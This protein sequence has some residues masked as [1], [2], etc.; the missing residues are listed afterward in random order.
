[1]PQDLTI[2]HEPVLLSG[3]DFFTVTA[4]EGSLICLSVEGEIIGV[5]EGTG[6]PV[7]ISIE[8]QIP[9]TMVDIVITKQ[10]FFRYETQVQVIPPDGPYVVKHS[11]E[12]NDANGNGQMDYGESILLS[13]AVKNV[14]NE[15]ATNVTVTIGT[16][17][18]YI[19]ITDGTEFY[20][21]VPA[22]SV[23][24]IVDGYAFDVAAD[25][26]DG[27][28]VNFSVVA[29][30]GTDTWNSG[31]SIEG[32]APV[33][34]FAEFVVSGDG[35][36]DPGE[37]VD[38]AITIENTGTSEAFNVMGELLINDP[39]VTINT[40]SQNYGN[41]EG[42]ATAEQSFSVTANANTP[43]GHMAN[44]IVEIAADFGI[45]GLGNFNVV[46]GQIP[47]LILDFDDNTNS[48][49]NMVNS[50]ENLG[51]ACEYVTSM[52]A[53]LNLYTSI[54]VCLGIYSDNH[55]L[56]SGE[57]SILA[58]Y[59]N[60]GGQ[61]YMEG[62]DTWYY[63][64]Q[65]AVHSM[66]NINPQADGSSDLGTILGQAGTIT[67]GLNYNYSGQNS[68]ID[69]INAISPAQLIHQNQSPVY[70]CGVAYDAG[71]YRTIGTS[72]EFGGLD[73]GASTVDQLMEQYLIFFGFGQEP[74]IQTITLNTG[75]QFS[76]TRIAVENPDML[77]VLEPILNENLDFV[78]NSNGEVLRKIGP[79]WVN[80]I[81]DWVTTGGYLF[82]M[83]GAEVLNIEGEVISATTPINLFAGY[84]F[85]SYLPDVPLDAIVAFDNILTDNL[86]Y[87]RNSNGEMLRKIGPNWVNGL[88]DLNPGEGYLVKMFADDLL[89]YN[90]TTDG[91]KNTY[92]PKVMNHFTF[93]GGNPAEAV[94][95]LYVSGLNIGD[96]VAVYDGDKMVGASVVISENTLENSIPVFSILTNGLGYESNNEMTL[97]V[98]D[99][100]Y[101]TTVSAT[102]TYDNEYAQAYTETGF[103][104]TD[105]Q[106]SVLNVTKGSLGMMENAAL[107]VDI[108]PNPTSDVLNIVS[109]NTI[110]RVRV[111]NFVGQT[112][113]DN[114]VNETNL[115]INT[116]VYQSGVYI[117]QIE[118]TNG[119]KTEKIT[120]KHR[121]SRN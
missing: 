34:E 26:P 32:H 105:G 77:V 46:I 102:Y 57:G 121:Y 61:L 107:E 14:G 31:F 109:N 17:D 72:F 20:G 115:S 15:D 43:A 55:V 2:N 117:I 73:D 90:V 97:K 4:N 21:L 56:T 19:T 51:M 16:E 96:E 104:A 93:E 58:A 13:L 69:R 120:I 64:N 116:S 85:V 37:T 30:D 50:I 100:Q 112:M 86:D 92:T 79:N 6:G 81:G 74:D 47:V 68:W 119:I 94:Y 44:F 11:Y 28:N 39:Y 113:L 60:N 62:G 40:S 83:F 63:D 71:D 38:I 89:V 84:Q 49:P 27:H 110:K 101:Q 106:Y 75:Y 111:L 1:M 42:G 70:G 48:G 18:E 66:F 8:P 65:T 35:K 29:T 23:V 78:R 9:P 36:I 10:N 91:V 87:I 67:E 25:I 52:P 103:P 5:A 33:L 12:I 7:D 114:E 59:L 118:T 22:N 76:S 95:S 24:N 3:P 80:G 99:T 45:A 88:G 54:F 98:W 108:Y 82:K 53:D 41:V